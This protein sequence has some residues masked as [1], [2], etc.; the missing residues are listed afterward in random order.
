MAGDDRGGGV[1]DIEEADDVADEMELR[2]LIDRLGGIGLPVAALVGRNDVVARVA[3]RADAG[4]ATSTS[5]PESRGTAR[6][7]ARLP[8]PGSGDVHL[9]PVGVDETVR[10]LGHRAIVG[11]GRLP[12]HGEP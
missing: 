4:V 5:S 3:E 2:V 1:E 10:D 11:D 7:A 8:G 9:D 12:C 6:R